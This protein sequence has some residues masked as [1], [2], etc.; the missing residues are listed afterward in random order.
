MKKRQL[1]LFV[2]MSTC[3]SQ[4]SLDVRVIPRIDAL[5]TGSIIA[6]L[7]SSNIEH[8]WVLSDEMQRNFVLLA[9]MVI[10][11]EVDHSSIA[12]SSFCV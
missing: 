10:Q 1:D 12:R 3:S 7:A 5:S 8:L 11:C 6:P 2:T 4:L 9:L